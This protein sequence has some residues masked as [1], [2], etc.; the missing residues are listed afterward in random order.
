MVMHVEQKSYGTPFSGNAYGKLL[1]RTWT[2]PDSKQLAAPNPHEHAVDEENPKDRHGYGCDWA[3][4][5][6]SR[7]RRGVIY[8]DHA[9]AD[10]TAA[11]D[12]GH[13]DET[14][15]LQYRTVGLA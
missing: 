15:R 4:K 13:S 7:A 9:A 2:G 3:R 6:V 8:A 1:K 14:E 10:R 5:V 11:E 12:Q